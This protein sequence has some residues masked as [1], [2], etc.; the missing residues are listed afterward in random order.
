MRDHPFQI[1]YQQIGGRL[2][3]GRATITIAV[4]AGFALGIVSPGAVP[5]AKV[6]A[7]QIL[8]PQHE[9]DGVIPGGH[10]RLDAICLLQG[11]FKQRGRDI[12]RINRFARQREAGVRDDVENGGFVFIGRPAIGGVNIVDQTFVQRPGVHF[13][14]PVI[15]DG[16]AKAEHFGLLIGHARGKPCITGRLKRVCRR[17]RD[18]SVHSRLQHLCGGEAVAIIRLGDIG[19]GFQHSRFRHSIIRHG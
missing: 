7:V 15:H 10:V 8:A 14:F 1:R 2:Q 3:I 4:G 5:R 12:G 17:V 18:Q 19:V 6:G 13:A 11:L 16:I 9:F